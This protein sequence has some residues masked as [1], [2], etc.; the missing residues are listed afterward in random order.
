MRQQLAPGGGRGRRSRGHQHGGWPPR[1]L[2]AEAALELSQIQREYTG[3][4]AP[5]AGQISRALVT[6]GNLV[7]QNETTLLTTIVSMDPLYVYYDAPERDLVEYQR[8]L[9]AG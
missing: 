2:E 9:Q 1:L 5:I 4:K 3:I 8:S 7:G 6:R